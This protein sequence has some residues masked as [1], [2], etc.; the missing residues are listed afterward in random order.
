VEQLRAENR[1]LLDEMQR[2]PKLGSFATSAAARME[3]LHG[4]EAAPLAVGV[5]IFDPSERQGLVVVY[6]MP[7]RS[8]GVYQLWLI[9][10]GTRVSGGVFRVDERGNG[11]LLVESPEPLERYE[12]V[13]VTAE[14]WARAQPAGSR[15]LSGALR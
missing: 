6:G 14:P 13:G 2:Q 9:R 15:L 3:E 10:E 4:T 7:P 5:L 11:R 1:Q 8:E 12:A